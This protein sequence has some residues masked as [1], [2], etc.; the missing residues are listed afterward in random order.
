MYKWEIRESVSLPRNYHGHSPNL[1]IGAF[2]SLFLTCTMIYCTSPLFCPGSQNR[3]VEWYKR[4]NFPHAWSDSPALT[5]PA[6]FDSGTLFFASFPGILRMSNQPYHLLR[7]RVPDTF[8]VVQSATPP[9]ASRPQ[10]APPISLHSFGPPL[11]PQS[12]SYALPSAPTGEP[13]PASQ[14]QSSISQTRFTVPPQPFSG[15]PYVLSRPPYFGTYIPAVGPQT[16]IKP[17]ARP[18]DFVANNPFQISHGKDKALLWQAPT[19]GSSPPNPEKVAACGVDVSLFRL[20]GKVILRY[21]SVTLPMQIYLLFLL[22]LPSLYSSRVD[23]IFEEVDITLPEI[24]STV[25]KLASQ[26][27]N[28]FEIEVAFESSPVHKRL[29]STW[30]SFIDSVMREWKIFNII[31]VLLLTYVNPFLFHT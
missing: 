19:A 3:K 24:K 2:N 13:T 4:A 12:A 5:L 17:D 8:L 1:S 6:P 9:Q 11:T 28:R 25:L 14:A 16:I 20:H 29:A 26:G 23:C 27:L 31:S 22:R 21:L 30:E 15:G 10:S 18:G 7:R